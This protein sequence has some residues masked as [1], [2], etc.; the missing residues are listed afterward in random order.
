MRGKVFLI[1]VQRAAR[2]LG[3]TFPIAIDNDFAIWK[4]F[5]NQ[6]WPAHCFVDAQGRIRFHHFGGGEYER[7]ERVIRQL[8]DEA[9]GAGAAGKRAAATASPSTAG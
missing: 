2:D 6:Y 1:D 8:I 5:A 4:S 9:R 7:S 3:L